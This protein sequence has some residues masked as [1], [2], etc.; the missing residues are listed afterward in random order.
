VS[1][2]LGRLTRNAAINVS[3]QAWLALVSL[4]TTPILYH[5]LG[6]DQYGLFSVVNI[7]IAQLTVLEL[8]FGHATTRFLAAALGRGDR[9]AQRRVVAVSLLVF[10][11]A[12]ALGAVL[13]LTAAGW[14][15]R[16]YFRLP[17]ALQPAGR[18]ALA[19]SAALFLVSMLINCA[20]AVWRGLQ[21]FG[22][23]NL[24]RGATGTAQTLGAVAV[25]WLGGKVLDVVAWTLLVACAGLLAHLL[26]LARAAP[27]LLGWPRASLPTLRQMAGFGGLLMLAGILTQLY[28]SGGPLL[29]A[30]FVVVGALPYYAVP[31]GLFQRLL[32]IASAVAAALLPMVAGLAESGATGVL[33]ELPGRGSRLLLLA[34]LPAAV[35]GGLLARPFLTLWLG[36]G[37]A[38]S[39]TWTLQCCLAAFVL[40]MVAVP[41]TELARGSGQAA[42]IVAYCAVLAGTNLA[43]TLALAPGWGVSGAATALLI[44]QLAG[45]AFLL[46]RSGLA[47]PTLRLLVRPLLVGLAYAVAS[48]AAASLVASLAGR[49]V[50][51]GALASAYAWAAWQVGLDLRERQVILRAL[52]ASRA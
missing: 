51:A 13:L 23:L 25:V 46:L 45:M 14:L 50:A 36:S 3:H 37:F 32:G 11:A 39:A 40:V 2:L 18:R 15:S 19:L 6:S 26:L 30:R 52:G 16:S 5:R 27:G 29:L 48:F 4:A 41:W 33:R 43:G 9:D 21:R 38:D 10:L 47:L 44:S 12:G 31:M 22:T 28:L 35:A 24:V 8:G 20:G 49:G 1:S 17:E 42:V 7:V 34:S